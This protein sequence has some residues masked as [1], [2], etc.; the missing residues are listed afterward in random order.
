MPGQK[1]M[2]I[3]IVEDDALIASVMEDI[4]VMAGH[5]IVGFAR[6]IN[7]ALATAEVLRC[8][9]ALVDFVLAR[10][11][12]GGDAARLLRTRYKIPSIFVSGSGH[13]CRKL[14]IESAALGC[15]PKPFKP[16]ELVATVATVEAILS[17]LAT[18][19]SPETFELY[20]TG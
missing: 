17:G 4:L 1:I 9:L 16:E 14:A 7:A 11:D 18:Q 20:P 2:R 5:V 19:N 10:G 6:D 13:E 3:L 12:S 15:L 8:D